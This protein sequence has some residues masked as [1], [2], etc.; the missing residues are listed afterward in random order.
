MSDSF[1][2]PRLQANATTAKQLFSNDAMGSA[3]LFAE[4]GFLPIYGKVKSLKHWAS[5]NPADATYVVTI[6][7]VDDAIVY[8]SGAITKNQFT[9]VNLTNNNALLLCGLYKVRSTFITSQTLSAND[10]QLLPIF[11]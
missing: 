1:A 9:F 11:K 3:G 8:T 10:F 7:D 2:D 5:N 4:S 6:R